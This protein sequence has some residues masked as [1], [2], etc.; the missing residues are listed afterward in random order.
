MHIQAIRA[1]ADAG[2]DEV[3]INQAGPEQEPFFEFYAGEVLSRLRG[4]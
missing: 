4:E 1:Y 3:Y 2:F